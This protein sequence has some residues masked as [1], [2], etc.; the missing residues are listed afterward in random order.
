MS[1]RKAKETKVKAAPAKKTKRVKAAPAPVVTTA[2]TAPQ[3]EAR[4]VQ[5][6]VKRP[7]AGGLCAQVWDALDALRASGVD[8]ATKDARDLALAKGWNQ[9]NAVAELSAW[10]KFHGIARSVLR[11]PVHQIDST[12]DAAHA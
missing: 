4:V 11:A 12:P 10:R 8:P 1:K 9:N 2:A 5:N 7:R 6:G 3:A